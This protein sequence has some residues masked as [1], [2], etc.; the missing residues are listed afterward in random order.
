M[1]VQSVTCSIRGDLRPT[2][3]AAGMI[4]I[5]ILGTDHLYQKHAYRK[6][7]I[8][9]SGQVSESTPSWCYAPFEPKGIL[10]F[11]T[12]SLACIISIQYVHI[13]IEFHIY[14]CCIFH[15]NC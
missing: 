5:Y 3:N 15:F 4:D 9:E 13:L 1:E 12:T 7:K 6:L 2:C 8:S 11:L 14:K 10:S